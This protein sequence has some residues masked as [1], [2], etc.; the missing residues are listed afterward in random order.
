VNTDLIKDA[1]KLATTTDPSKGNAYCDVVDSL[2]ALKSDKQYEG[3]TGAYFLE[4]IVAE[5]AIDSSKA[6]SFLKNYTNISSTI[7]NQRLSVMGVDQDEEGMDILK[8][9][10]AYNLSSKMMSIMNEIYN[11]LINETGV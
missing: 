5:V 2:V 1:T 8:F 11:K 9:Q 10:Q 4:S 6:T 7:N 3:G